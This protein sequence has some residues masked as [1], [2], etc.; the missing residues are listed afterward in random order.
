MF[1]T[2]FLNKTQLK[3]IFFFILLGRTWFNAFL[4]L[5]QTG[6]AGTVE[7]CFT[8]HWRKPMNSGSTVHGRQPMN[9]GAWH[10]CSWVF[11]SEEAATSCFLYTCGC[12]TVNGGT[13]Q[14]KIAVGAL[15]N[16]NICGCGWGSPAATIPNGAE[17]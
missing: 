1:N 10:H 6:L 4:A 14:F 9:S 8:V 5:N 16:N 15:P 13:H 11:S 7:P 12:A 2:S 3:I 17:V